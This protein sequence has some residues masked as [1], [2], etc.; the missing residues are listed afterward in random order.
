MDEDSGIAPRPR[1][2]WRSPRP[3]PVDA[4]AWPQLVVAAI[5]GA[6][7]VLGLF[8]ALLYLPPHPSTPIL[9]GVSILM[10]TRGAYGAWKVGVAEPRVKGAARA[11]TWS[12]SGSALVVLAVTAVLGAG[13]LA[14]AWGDL[15]GP[16]RRTPAPPTVTFEPP[17]R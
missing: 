10:V 5:G 1:P 6:L 11:A 9:A 13:A 7:G 14:P 16:P 17:A 8:A 12:L 2:G 3:A 4:Q 15:L